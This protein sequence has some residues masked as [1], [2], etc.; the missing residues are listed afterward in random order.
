M[1]FNKIDILTWSRK[2]AYNHYLKDV[3]C[4]YSMTVNLDI[5]A[6][7]KTVKQRKLKFFP[8]MLYGITHTVNHH[9]EF[10]M[11]FD[12]MK[13]LGYYSYLNPCYTVFHSENETFTDVWTEYSSDLDVFIENYNADMLK[14]QN[15]FAHSKPL[16]SNNLFNVSCIP[17][18]SFTGF[19]LNLQKGYDY[20]PPI[21]TVGKYFLNG[22]KT[23]LP[24]AI[25]VHHAI[26]DG[27][28]LSRF[29]NDLQKWID[30]FAK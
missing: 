11:D 12:E 7:I 5:T 26:C 9:E 1:T 4:T 21:F 24:L 10:R 15:N 16:V 30:T 28:H 22:S 23:L 25:Q 3:P 13:C 17:W 19:N 8:V 20:F 27:F 6:F 18:S 29:I 14:Y 2:E